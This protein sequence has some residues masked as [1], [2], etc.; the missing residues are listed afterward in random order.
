LYDVRSG[1]PVVE[2]SAQGI[3]VVQSVRSVAKVEVRIDRQQAH[4][5][6]GT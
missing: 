1:H 2:Q 4:A 6:K 3:A 5:L